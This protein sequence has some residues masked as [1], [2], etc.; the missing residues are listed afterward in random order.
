MN[1]NSIKINRY[2]KKKTSGTIQFYFE[3]WYDPD[4]F[5]V[6]KEKFENGKY[7]NTNITLYSYI[8]FIKSVY[9]DGPTRGIDFF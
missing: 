4:G 3:N 1:I 7:G 2:N 8:K 6:E 9:Q 5:S